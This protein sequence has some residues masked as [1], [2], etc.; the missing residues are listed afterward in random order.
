MANIMILDEI[1]KDQLQKLQESDIDTTE[2]LLNRANSPKARQALARQIGVDEETVLEWAMH[3]DLFRV[4]GMDGNYA[5]LLKAVG[6]ETVQMLEERTA[7]SLYQE[8]EEVNR[9]QGLAPETPTKG[10][11]ESWIDQ[12]KQLPEVIKY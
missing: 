5:D 3:A 10:Q 9:E 8:L 1:P 4:S 7:E 11:V 12:A 2:D 6:V